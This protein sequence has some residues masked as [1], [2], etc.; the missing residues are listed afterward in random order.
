[1]KGTY[2]DG[3]GIRLDAQGSEEGSVPVGDSG[4]QSPGRGINALEVGKSLCGITADQGR[5]GRDGRGEDEDRG[6]VD[7]FGGCLV[8][9]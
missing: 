2:A 6:E 5:E 8:G 1:M 4:G 7:H 3:I 9:S